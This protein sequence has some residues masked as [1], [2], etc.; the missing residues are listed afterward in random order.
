MAAGEAGEAAEEAE[1]EV[2]RLVEAA[3]RD[4]QVVVAA[5]GQVG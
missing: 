4:R 1:A 5:G 3:A 2:A